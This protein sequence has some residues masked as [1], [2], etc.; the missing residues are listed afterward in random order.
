MK[1]NRL[2]KLPVIAVIT[3]VCAFPLFTFEWPQENVS[4]EKF[5]S[6][7]LRLVKKPG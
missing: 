3:G 2:K 4:A 1:L 7:L 5:F 6:F